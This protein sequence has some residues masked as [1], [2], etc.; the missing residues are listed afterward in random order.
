MIPKLIVSVLLVCDPRLAALFTPPHPQWGSYQVCTAAAS[1]DAVQA[2]DSSVNYGPRQL[3][4]ALDAFG[5][6]GPYD[7]SKLA[8]LYG[9]RRASVVHG[10][11]M[12]DGVFETWTLISPYP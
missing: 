4:N 8:R 12:R 1:E 10:W 2:I 7:R 3:I 11:A 5:L 9:G 6:A